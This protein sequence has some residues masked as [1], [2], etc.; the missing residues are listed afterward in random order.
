MA[1][2]WIKFDTS[3]PDKPEIFIIADSL[4]IDPDAVVGKLL[5]VWTWFDEHTV[6]GNAPSVS[7]ILLDRLTGVNGFCNVVIDAGWMIDEN[8]LLKLPNFDRHNGETAKKRA[9]TAKRVAKHKLKTNAN[10][11]ADGVSEN[12]NDALP[13]EEKRRIKEYKEKSFDQFWSIWPKKVAKD[14]AKKAFL[15]INLD[16]L[17]L[18][19]ILKAVRE[20]SKNW[21]DKQFIPNPSTWINQKRW[22]DEID[23]KE[24]YSLEDYAE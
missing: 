13:R 6:D 18:A 9:L 10:G 24:S 17:L 1:G 19:K 23:R 15:K 5:R 4:N 12:V 16:D 21:K 20:Q 2:D 3:T 7:K 22:E 14:P 8:G 11:N